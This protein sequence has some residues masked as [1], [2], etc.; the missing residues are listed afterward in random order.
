[1]WRRKRSRRETG[2]NGKPPANCRRRRR[3][4][5]TDIRIRRERRKPHRL[6][7]SSI[8]NSNNNNYSSNHNTNNTAGATTRDHNKW[9]RIFNNHNNIINKN[10]NTAATTTRVFCRRSL[11]SIS[12]RK[13]PPFTPGI[14]RWRR[15]PDWR[16][17]IPP[18]PTQLPTSAASTRRGPRS[19]D[20][21][22]PLGKPRKD[23]RPK[24]SRFSSVDDK[25][26]TMMTTK[27]TPTLLTR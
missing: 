8:P 9:R 15:R 12:T 6:S 22:T 2:G 25:M 4:F 27:T 13:F 20:L 23:S 24:Q 1:M 10:N 3:R 19:G 26:T 16:R 17:Q 21:E 14:R 11:K 18:P 7:L 5:V